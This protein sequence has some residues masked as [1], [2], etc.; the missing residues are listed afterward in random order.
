MRRKLASIWPALWRGAIALLT[1]E[2]VT[3]SV[4]RYFTDMQSPPGVILANA[5]A[6]PFLPL[7][8]IGGGAALA[9]GPAPF[10]R[11]IRERVPAFPRAA[12][13]IYAAGFAPG[14][15]AG[16]MAAIGTKAGPIAALGF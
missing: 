2:I 16:F 9:V 1:L 11:R 4:L 5:F 6:K 12:G 7:H 3:V 8:W 13:K 15:P 14:A 10:V